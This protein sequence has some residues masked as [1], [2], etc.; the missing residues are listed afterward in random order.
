MDVVDIRGTLPLINHQLT[1]EAESRERIYPSDRRGVQSRGLS[2]YPPVE[3]VPVVPPSLLW[4]F[5]QPVRKLPQ[6]LDELLSD[7]PDVSLHFPLISRVV[8]MCEQW[9][10]PVAPAPSL[11]CLLELSAVVREYLFR[12]PAELAQE[13]DKFFGGR[14]GVELCTQ[15]NL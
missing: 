14:L 7:V 3:P 5:A 12:L 4:D 11:P 15:K 9:F 10:Y 6:Q 2:V 13:P 1:G 8:R